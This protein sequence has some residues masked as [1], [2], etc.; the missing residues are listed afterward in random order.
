MPRK[1]TK[2]FLG[3][4]ITDLWIIGSAYNLLNNYFTSEKD[5]ALYGHDSN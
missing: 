3:K 5:K 2:D 1:N 4:R